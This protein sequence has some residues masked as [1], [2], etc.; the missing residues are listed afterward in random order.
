MSLIGPI[1]L[2]EDS[3][4]LAL[5]VVEALG[6]IA[7]VETRTTLAAAVIAAEDGRH[8]LVV[9]DLGLPDAAPEDVV[10]SLRRS[11]AGVPVVVLTGNPAAASLAAGAADVLSKTAILDGALVEAVRRHTGTRA[12]V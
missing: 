6:D 10:P 9:A 7:D 8:A 1:L 2:V 3:P 11:A 5:L 4:D 12:P